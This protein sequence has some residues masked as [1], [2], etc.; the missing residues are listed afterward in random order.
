MKTTRAITAAL[1][2]ALILSLAACDRTPETRTTA[3]PAVLTVQRDSLA[4]PD[5]PGSVAIVLDAPADTLS[6]LSRAIG[7]YVSETLGGTWEGSC[8]DYDGMLN[9]Y[10]SIL[11]ATY[12]DMFSDGLDGSDCFD[13][14]EILKLAENTKYVTYITTR[15]LY[16]GGAHGSQ[17]ISGMTFRKADGRRIG[18]DVFTGRYDDDFAALLKNGLKEY[19]GIDSD[20]ELRSY[21]LDE[22]DYYTV[23]LPDCPPLFTEDGVRFVYNEYELAAYAYGRPSFTL[24][25]AELDDYMMVTAKRLL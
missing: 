7:E 25:Y 22:N 2:A 17:M 10:I 19:W 4:A 23:P 12:A 14:T 18:W 9:H 20:N 11:S 6:Q 8:T 15:E 1:T 16:L 3:T 24:P 5:G 21:F 13:Y